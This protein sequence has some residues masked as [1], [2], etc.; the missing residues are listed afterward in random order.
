MCAPT[1]SRNA[2]NSAAMVLSSDS[3]SGFFS[4]GPHL[5]CS[6]QGVPPVV[7]GIAMTSP[8]AM[9]VVAPEVAIDMV[10]YPMP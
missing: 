8:V 6:K 5:V 3:L 10:G 9:V 1:G 2:G 4:S 7:E